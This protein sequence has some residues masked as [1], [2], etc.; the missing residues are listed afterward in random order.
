[1][2]KNRRIADMV[3]SLIPYSIWRSTPDAVTIAR[4]RT[5]VTVLAFSIVVPAIALLMV[6]GL[7]FFSGRDFTPAMVSLVGVI[8][9]LVTQH[10]LFQSSAN[11][12]ITGVAYSITFFVLLTAATVFTGGWGS[13]VVPLLFCTPIMVFLIS[14]WREA[15]IA[16]LFTFATGLVLMLLDIMH[17]ELPY[18]MHKENQAYAQG[19]VWFMACFILVMLFGTQKWVHGLDVDSN[20]SL[21]DSRPPK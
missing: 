18:L 16:V 17:V 12:Y 13:P 6:V 21:D 15:E 8:V 4:A 20:I 1:M 19:V 7:H 5:L 9:V 10:L 11:L 2:F 3:D 14:G